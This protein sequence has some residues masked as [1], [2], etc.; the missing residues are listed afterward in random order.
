M[1]SYSKVKLGTETVSTSYAND[2]TRL[3]PIIKLKVSGYSPAGVPIYEIPKWVR[4]GMIQEIFGGYGWVLATAQTTSTS[5]TT[6]TSTSRST[7]TTTT[8]NVSPT[9]IINTSAGTLDSTP[10]IEFTGTDS[11]SNEIEYNIQIATDNSFTETTANVDFWD[12]SEDVTTPLK[13]FSG[14]NNMAGQSFTGDGGVLNSCKFKLKESSL[15]PG[16][17]RA[18]IYAE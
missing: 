18:V 15:P 9:V 12:G 17:A 2:S 13:Y 16:N 7:S 11:E 14:A 10:T 3:I 8:L 1:K 6:S 5:K 4:A